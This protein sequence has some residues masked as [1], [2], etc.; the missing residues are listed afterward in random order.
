MNST[1]LRLP[2]QA[3]PGDALLPDHPMGRWA[4]GALLTGTSE[5]VVSQTVP[6]SDLPESVRTWTTVAANA[7]LG[8]FRLEIA[9]RPAARQGEIGRRGQPEGRPLP[10]QSTS[11]PTTERGDA[12]G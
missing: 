6:L 8:A 2:A 3:A 5:A 4:L 9:E 1:P 10:P 11:R 12:R 7:G